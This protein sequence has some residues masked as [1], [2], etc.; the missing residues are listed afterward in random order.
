MS[1]LNE[2]VIK[3]PKSLPWPL[4]RGPSRHFAAAN[5]CTAKGLPLHT[6]E[7]IGAN[8]HDRVTTV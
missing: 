5:C 2:M 6:I 7:L 8:H 1:A 4:K 3:T